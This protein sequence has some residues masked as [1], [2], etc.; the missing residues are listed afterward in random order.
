M[1]YTIEAYLAYLADA[2]EATI[3]EK[4]N[5]ANTWLDVFQTEYA[6]AGGR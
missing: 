1:D 3:Q 5:L 2:D 4:L 6:Q